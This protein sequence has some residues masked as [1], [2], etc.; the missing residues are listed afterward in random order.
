MKRNVALFC[1]SL[2]TLLFACRK[3]P[4]LS[5]LSTNFVVQTGVAPG[6]SF[7]EYKT[8]Y[9]SDTVAF[10][11]SNPNDSIL[12]D[13]L[14]KQLVAKLRTNLEARG[15][16]YV[17]KALKPDLG[18]NTVV[19]KDIDVGVYYPGWW[20]GYPGY[21]DPWYWGWYYPY[22]YPWSVAYAI[23]TGSVLT[24]IIDLKNVAANQKIEVVWS[25]SLNGA[26]STTTTT[27]VQRTMDGIDQAFVQSPYLTT[28]K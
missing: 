13:D 21:W 8:F 28:Q 17:P 26:L 24:D 20:W 14:A 9:I 5:E 12:T 11:S 18:V 23:S 2:L 4:D 27:N 16:T 6:T 25:M 22:Y 7:S 19:I 10:I 1:A 3:T 15:F